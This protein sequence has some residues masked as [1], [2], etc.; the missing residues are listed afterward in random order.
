MDLKNKKEYNIKPVNVKSDTH[1]RLV[2]IKF[3]T[4]DN[5]KNII[6]KAVNLYVKK[7]KV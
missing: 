2:E 5:Y 6:D 4:G 7:L 3:F 1:K